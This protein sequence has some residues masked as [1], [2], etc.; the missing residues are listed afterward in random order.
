MADEEKVAW[1]TVVSAGIGMLAFAAVVLLCNVAGS[2]VGE[3]N[4][5]LQMLACVFVMAVP[6]WVMRAVLLKSSGGEGV[7]AD[8]RDL[9]ITGRADQAQFRVLLLSSAIVLSLAFNETEHFW[10]ASTIFAGLGLSVI[11]GAVVQLR[12]YRSG[13]RAW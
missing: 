8:E 10:I 11:V 12:G 4:Y 7:G 1:T 2:V 9:E 3:Q 6:V 13:V 5:S